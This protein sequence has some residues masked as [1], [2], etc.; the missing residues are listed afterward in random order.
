MTEGCFVGACGVQVDAKGVKTA[1]P[2]PW[3]VCWSGSSWTSFSTGSAR[4]S[5][6]KSPQRSV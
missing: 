1:S 5:S 3:R 4:L 6:T 2:G